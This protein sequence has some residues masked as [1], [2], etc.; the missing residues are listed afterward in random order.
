M[1]RALTVTRLRVPEGHRAEYLAVLAE[2]EYLGRERGRH[3]WVFRSALDA[4]L[5]VE[6]SEAGGEGDLRQKS[7]ATGREAELEARWRALV[8]VEGP[9]DAPWLEVALPSPTA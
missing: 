2:L 6:F 1:S 7:P 8:S 5:F 9:A 4:D 3:L